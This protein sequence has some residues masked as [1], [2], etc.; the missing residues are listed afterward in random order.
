MGDSDAEGA[1][2]PPSPGG[3]SLDAEGGYLRSK[4]WWA[5]LGLM[6]L[7]ETGN[8][9][10]YGFA[11]ASVVAPLGTVAL[12]ANCFFAPLILR[13]SFTRR[14]VLGMTLAIVG[15]VTVVWSASDSNPRVSCT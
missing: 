9:V 13:E 14:N 12:I 11:P 1:E 3:S 15:A 6:G 8:F 7:G 10:S 4:L 2:D 5:G